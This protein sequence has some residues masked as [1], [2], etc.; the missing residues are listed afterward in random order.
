VDPLKTHDAHQPHH[1]RS[2]R[3]PQNR[4]FEDA[5]AE[6]SEVRLCESDSLRLGHIRKAAR[7]IREANVS[8]LAAEKVQDR[9]SGLA[10]PR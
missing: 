6:R 8:A 5:P 3:P 4:T 7:E 10:D 1:A 2:R 9:S